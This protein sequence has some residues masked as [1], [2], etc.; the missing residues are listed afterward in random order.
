MFVQLDHPVRRVRRKNIRCVLL[1]QDRLYLIYRKSTDEDTIL[2]IRSS[3]YHG[4]VQ[5]GQ[6]VQDNV[7][8]QV[9]KLLD[10]HEQNGSRFPMQ[11]EWYEICERTENGRMR[12]GVR[13]IRSAR[14]TTCG[15]WLSV[16]LQFLVAML[17]VT[18]TVFICRVQTVEWLK[19]LYPD[20]ARTDL[21]RCFVAVEYAGSALLFLLF[22]KCRSVI[23][24]LCNTVIPFCVLIAAGLFNQYWWMWLVM[25]VSVIVAMLIGVIWNACFTDDE[26]SASAYVRSALIVCG[27]ALLCVSNYFAF[28]GY[29]HK[30]YTS[31]LSDMTPKQAQHHTIDLFGEFE[32]QS[33]QDLDLDRKATLLQAVSDYE[34]LFVLGCEP[35][36]LEIG[37]MHHEDVLGEYDYVQRRIL[38]NRELVQSG[39]VE[40]VLE[41]LLHETRHVYQ[42]NLVDMYF[43][44]QGHIR[45]EY[46]DL[47]AFKQAREYSAEFEEYCHGETDFDRYY[48]QEVER[49]C[50]Q[51]A[52]KRMR[53]YYLCFVYPYR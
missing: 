14:H 13:R 34:C 28:H 6:T 40:K 41:T 7:Y 47:L 31:T 17:L 53:E 21:L 15:M 46:R 39:D 24:M 19:V 32:Y 2:S 48:D 18:L 10:L 11:G 12:T 3:A 30:T 4:F 25:P 20:T 44:L 51:W 45:K 38:L 5:T 33:W 16:G 50:R 37:S 9:G 27:I 8:E 52:E 22:P 23:G 26:S 36:V 49:D 43:S 35:V 1:Y 42:R 29:P